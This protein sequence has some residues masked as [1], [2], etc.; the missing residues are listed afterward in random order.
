MRYVVIEIL[1][2]VLVLMV[3]ENVINFFFVEV[4]YIILN[5][6][7]GCFLFVLKFVGFVRRRRGYSGGYEYIFFFFV[8]LVILDLFMGVGRCEVT[9]RVGFYREVRFWFWFIVGWIFVC[10]NVV[11]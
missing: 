2:N 9:G 3:L 5:V 7:E 8:S 1:L 11:Y 6:D 4:S 10:G